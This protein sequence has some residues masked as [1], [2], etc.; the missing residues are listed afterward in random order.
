METVRSRLPFISTRRSINPLY[1][2]ERFLTLYSYAGYCSCGDLNATQP[3]PKI[4]WIP[5]RTM[6]VP[7]QI[8][9]ILPSYMMYGDW[10]DRS[11]DDVL[12]IIDGIGTVMDIASGDRV[13]DAR[14]FLK[15]FYHFI[16][17]MGVE[18]RA[19]LAKGFV[20]IFPLHFMPLMDYLGSPSPYSLYESLPVIHAP[21]EDYSYPPP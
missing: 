5:E 11:I 6:F 16:A 4:D 13:F 2:F 8:S 3:G 20:Y 17:N 14:V 21:Q 10:W 9:K 7:L 19:D 15:L 12:G 1:N 18:G